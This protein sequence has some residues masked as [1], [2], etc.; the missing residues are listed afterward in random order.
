MEVKGILMK[1]IIIPEN[2][3]LFNK[4]CFLIEDRRWIN[5]NEFLKSNGSS[6][7]IK[8]NFWQRLK[9]LDREFLAISLGRYYRKKIMS[10]RE[11]HYLSDKKPTHVKLLD[12]LGLRFDKENKT[13]IFFEKKK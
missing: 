5:I 6:R 12:G 8:L 13:L 1:Q 11:Y 3:P 9:H 10:M 7:K 4:L 2:N